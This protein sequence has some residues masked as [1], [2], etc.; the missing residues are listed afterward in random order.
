MLLVLVRRYPKRDYTIGVLS[1]DGERL[2]NILEPPV[3][4]T[5]HGVT[6]I[7]AGTYRIDMTT[8]SPKFRNRSWAR[9][10]GGIVPT[11]V[12]VPGRSRILIH[13]GNRVEDTD[14]CLLTGL[15]TIVG[16][17]TS[18]VRCYE[19]VMDLLMTAKS[20]DIDSFIRIV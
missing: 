16:G 7:P 18:S 2:C 17:L 19:V 6:A 13:P 12:G 14:G 20:N 3:R 4:G 15:N 1:L 10:Y 8:V 9:P 5:H 11:L